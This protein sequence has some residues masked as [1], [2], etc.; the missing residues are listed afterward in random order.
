MG[1]EIRI[2]EAR[3][4]FDVFGEPEA[5]NNEP[6][7]KKRWSIVWLIPKD[8]P[9]KAEIDK[10]IQEMGRE[11]FGKQW[12][13]IWKQIE[14]NSNKCCWQDGDSKADKYEGYEGHFALSSHRYADSGRPLIMDN[15][16]SPIYN[17]TTNEFMPG[18][19]GR[20]YAGCWVRGKVEIYPYKKPSPGIAASFSVVQRLR[21]G[22]AF[23]GGKPPS[24]DDFDEVDDGA[25]D[26]AMGGEE[27]DAADDIG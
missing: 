15:D 27:G 23:G 17:M 14:F 8:S 13:S 12:P 6:G 26:G 19:A 3:Q 9:V 5:Y 11:T 10:A 24:A 20:L 22:D 16:K 1:K 4:S 7:G 25:D 2:P 21:P 18:K